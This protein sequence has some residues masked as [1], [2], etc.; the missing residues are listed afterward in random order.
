MTVAAAAAP[1][2]WVGLAALAAMFLLPYLGWLV[3]G[4]HT[5]RHRPRRHVCADC[6]L[7]WTRGHRCPPDLDPRPPAEILV[8]RRTQ[9]AEPGRRQLPHGPVDR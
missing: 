2:P 9:P 7:P 6:A 5:I 4:P 8:V 1:V 3:D